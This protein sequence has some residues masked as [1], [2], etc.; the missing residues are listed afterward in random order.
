[1]YCIMCVQ[2]NGNLDL[3]VKK[4]FLRK[5]FNIKWKMKD[6]A[7]EVSSRATKIKEGQKER[8]RET[9]PRAGWSWRCLDSRD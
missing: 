2:V 9:W 8:L 7:K 5:M 4:Y 3:I 1:M 6:N